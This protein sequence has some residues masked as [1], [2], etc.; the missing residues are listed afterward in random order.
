MATVRNQLP[1]I[2]TFASVIPPARATVFL[3]AAGG[4]PE[5]AL[6]LHDWNEAVGAAFYPSLQKVELGLRAKV[7][8]AMEATWGSDWF[9]DP[10]FLRINDYAV[11]K[12]VAT[13]IGRLKAREANVDADGLSDKA[14]FGLWVGLLRPIFNPP[15]WMT[16][17]RTSF[18]ALPATVGRH[19]LAS[20][21][22]HAANLRNRID[23]HETLIGLDLSADHADVMTL[24]GWID[25]PLAARARTTCTVRQL[26][27]AKP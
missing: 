7:G 26:L 16:Q 23:H 24:L 25:R 22:S 18:P 14:S 12:E 20:L 13:A 17:L 9:A 21:A 6:A 27:R 4:N 3:R 8:A 2:H 19:E 11:H 1:N 15:V 5:R 10:D